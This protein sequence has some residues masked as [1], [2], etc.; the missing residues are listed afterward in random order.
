MG[1]QQTVTVAAEQAGGALRRMI[2]ALLVAALMAAMMVVSAGSAFAAASDKANT[3]GRN[4]S[5]FNKVGHQ[6]GDNGLGGKLLAGEAPLG[7]VASSG[8]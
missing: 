8:R 2:L 6:N 3:V 5:F 4:A 7:D 1:Q